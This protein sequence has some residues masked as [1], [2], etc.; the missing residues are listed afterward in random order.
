MT[1]VCVIQARMGSSRLPGKVLMDLTPGETILERVVQ[2]LRRAETVDR[3]IVATTRDQ[4]DD[5][6]EQACHGL[7]VECVRGDTFDV[8]DRYVQAVAT[9]EDADVVVRVTADCPFVDPEIVDSLVRTLR[10]DQVD[11][12]A[13]RLPPP[14]ER[15]YPVGL[16]VEVCTREALEEAGRRAEEPHQREHVMPYLY[17][18]PGDFRI[19]VVDLPEDLAMHRWTVDTPEDLEVVR[20]IAEAV[21]PEPFSWRKVFDVT[22]SDAGIEAMNAGQRQKLVTDVDERR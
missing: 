10:A 17:E 11:F 6:I 8:L 22:A 1:T 9:V 5:A 12:I 3:I 20:K 18:H 4:G 16:D 19:R 21:G 13:N 7:A 15:T 14:H 2:R